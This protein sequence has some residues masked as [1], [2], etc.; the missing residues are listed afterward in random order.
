MIK[1]ELEKA[2]TFGDIELEKKKLQLAPDADDARIM[3]ADEDPLGFLYAKKWLAD[4]MKEIND[5][6]DYEAVRTIA[7]QM[8]AEE[9]TRMQTKQ[10]ARM[11]G[12][13]R[14]KHIPPGARCIPLGA[15]A[16]PVIRSHWPRLD[17]DFSLTCPVY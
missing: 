5:R 11:H 8:Q 6:R 9:T 16:R 1:R 15:G 3:L 10:P 17:I 14:A 12:A 7:T 13:G 4:K 2:K